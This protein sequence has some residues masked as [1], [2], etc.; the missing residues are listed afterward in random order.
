MHLYYIEHTFLLVT[1]SLHIQ[2][3]VRAQ[4]VGNFGQSQ[5]FQMGEVFT[6]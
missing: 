6:L 3:E 5:C 2:N 1:K 4:G